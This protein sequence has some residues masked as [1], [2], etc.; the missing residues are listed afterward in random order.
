MV[1]VAG[2]RPLRTLADT[3]ALAHETA[4]VLPH[5]Q[6]LLLSGPLGA[7]KTTFVAALAAALGSPAD[8]TSPTYTLVHEYPC[9]TGPL[10]HIDLYRLPKGIDL[11]GA[12]DLED[13]L[14]RA[15]AVVVEWGERL[16]ATHPEG[17]HLTLTRHREERS[18]RW[19]PGHGPA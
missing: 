2:E 8:V 18:A 4:R 10:I 17:W 5:G 1:T 7:G 6:L 16:L 15:R 12:L 14:G 19:D 9:S 3:V 11:E 13:A